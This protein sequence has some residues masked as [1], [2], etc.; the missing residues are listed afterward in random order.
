M[1]SASTDII[2]SDISFFE[3]PVNGTVEITKHGASPDEDPPEVRVDTLS[4]PEDATVC[5]A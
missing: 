3:E 1:K 4:N 5:R 2:I